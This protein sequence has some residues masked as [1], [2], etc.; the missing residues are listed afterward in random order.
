MPHRHSTDAGTPRLQGPGVAA[1]GAR[2]AAPRRLRDAREGGHPS[3]ILGCA[4]R[5]R[6]RVVGRGG[7]RSSRGR[8]DPSRMSMATLPKAHLLIPE[9]PWVARAVRPMGLSLM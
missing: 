8:A 2:C 6:Y 9:K 7:L 5:G 3:C 4:G 1:E